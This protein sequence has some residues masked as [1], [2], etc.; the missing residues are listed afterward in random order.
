[1]PGLSGVLRR[2]LRAAENQGRLV[3]INIDEYLTSQICHNCQQRTLR[4]MQIDDMKLHTVLHC[5]NNHCR[6][7]WNRDKNAA[8]NIYQI[9]RSHIFG[10]GRPLPFARPSP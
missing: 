7:M 8:K 2:K 6:T 5:T 1:M 10:Q 9:A 4:N 3:V